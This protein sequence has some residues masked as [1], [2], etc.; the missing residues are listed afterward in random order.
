MENLAE[1]VAT[2][3]P[4]R[5]PV[6]AVAV[7]GMLIG[8]AAANFWYSS[9]TDPLPARDLALALGVHHWR[10]TIPSNDGTQVLSLELR[11][12]DGVKMHGGSSGWASGE[13]ILVTARPLMDSGN[14]ECSFVGKKSHSRFVIDNPFRKLGAI[15][16]ADDGAIVNDQP[17]IK[18]ST[19]GE[20]TIIPVKSSKP[21][22]ITLRVVLGPSEANRPTTDAQ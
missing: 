16:Y 8:I 1:P 21:G 18:G 20:I 2:R 11:N 3:S 5:T 12:D 4:R 17:L 14:L 15:H 13:T 6:I 22:D 19:S 10:Y 9:R 7:V